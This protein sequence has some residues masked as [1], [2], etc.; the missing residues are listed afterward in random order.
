MNLEAKNKI[1]G[2]KA[3]GKGGIRKTT[4][5]TLKRALPEVQVALRPLMV[6][7]VLRFVEVPAV[8]ATFSIGK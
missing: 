1:K 7:V 6:V 4:L 8:L 5:V 3:K 2:M